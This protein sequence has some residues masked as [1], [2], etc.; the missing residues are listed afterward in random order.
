M[1]SYLSSQIFTQWD[2][3]IF[4]VLV[5][6][7]DFLASAALPVSLERAL[8]KWSKLSLSETKSQQTIATLFKYNGEL[9]KAASAL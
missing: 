4:T 8:F 7:L 1:Q 9:I 2:E 6:E 5:T 3:H